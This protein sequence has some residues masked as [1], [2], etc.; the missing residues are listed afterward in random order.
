MSRSVS[1]ARGWGIPVPGDPGQVIYV[2]WDALSNYISALG[3]GTGSTTTGTGGPAPTGASTWSAR[4]CVRFHA[5]YWPAILLSAGEPLPTEILVHDYLTA[6]GRKISKSGGAGDLA[7]PVALAGR[8]GTDAV[9]WW[10]LRE[11]PRV[12]RRRLHR[13]AAGRA[14]QPGPGQRPGQPGQPGDLAGAQSRP[15]RPGGPGR[16]AD[17]ASP[18][19]PARQRRRPRPRPP[20]AAPSRRPP[21]WSGPRWTDYDFRAATRGDL[22][23]RGPGQ[24]VRRAQRAMA[25]G[26][27]GQGGRCGRGGLA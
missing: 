18:T 21:G 5:V 2:W 27:G 10:L 25:A 17:A 13:G 1:R 23:D 8:Y 11:V 15:G 6:G 12:G 14:G 16:P 3:Y 19:R 4:A 7:D 24:P 26:Q 22:G 20:W 9:R